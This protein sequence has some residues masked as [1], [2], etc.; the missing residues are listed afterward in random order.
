MRNEPECKWALLLV[1][2]V[3]KKIRSA[4]TFENIVAKS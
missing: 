1:D 3:F 2:E 4:N